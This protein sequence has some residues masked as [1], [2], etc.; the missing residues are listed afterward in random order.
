LPLLAVVSAAEEV[1]LGV[2]PSAAIDAEEEDTGEEKLPPR[3]R[4]SNRGDGKPM[5]MA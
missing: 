4:W 1:V 5:G 3:L 2:F